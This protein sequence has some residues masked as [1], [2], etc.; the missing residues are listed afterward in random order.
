M[1]CFD[2]LGHGLWGRFPIYDI[3]GILMCYDPCLKGK[4]ILAQGSALG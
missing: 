2:T 3:F 1:L 4:Q